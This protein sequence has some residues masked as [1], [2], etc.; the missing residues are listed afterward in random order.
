[1]IVPLF[2]NISIH[3]P[4]FKWSGRQ[5]QV[6]RCLNI[7]L[8]DFKQMY[9][10]QTN[11]NA[12]TCLWLF[13]FPVKTNHFR[14]GKNRKITLYLFPVTVTH[15]S[16]DSFAHQ[17]LLS[18]VQELWAR[19]CTHSPMSSLCPKAKFYDQYWCKSTSYVAIGWIKLCHYIFLHRTRYLQTF[20]RLWYCLAA[21]LDLLIQGYSLLTE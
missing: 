12:K 21:P 6:L 8:Y 2:F 10:L 9:A 17:W 7:L 14:L 1:M 20:I 5:D 19:M 16:E 11:G 18:Q 3:H 15:E 4:V 13:F